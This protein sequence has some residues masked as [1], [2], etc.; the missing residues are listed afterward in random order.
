MLQFLLPRIPG[1]C[2]SNIDR[3]I[4]VILFFAAPCNKGHIWCTTKNPLAAEIKWCHY[5]GTNLDAHSRNALNGTETI[6]EN[7]LTNKP[8]EPQNIIV[9]IGKHESRRPRHMAKAEKPTPVIVAYSNFISTIKL[10]NMM[11]KYL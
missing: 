1:Q 8:Q 6:L 3:R 2:L 4:P 9:S 7:Y 10:L 5:S 11:S